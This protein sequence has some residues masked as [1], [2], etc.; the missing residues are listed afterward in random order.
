M[1]PHLYGSNTWRKCECVPARISYSVCSV[2]DVLNIS[3]S[4]QGREK[5][6]AKMGERDIGACATGEQ[7]RSTKK[8]T[9]ASITAPNI[10][11]NRG[12]SDKP[13]GPSSFTTQSKW[14]NGIFLPNVTV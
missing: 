14:M 1:Q 11:G 10:P 2:C 7:S 3:K 13:R 12:R 5:K 4:M 8:V 9:I 6:M